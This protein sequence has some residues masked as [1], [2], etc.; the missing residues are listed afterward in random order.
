MSDFAKIVESYNGVS[1]FPTVGDPE[2]TY[3]DLIGGYEYR[4]VT[5][6]AAGVDAGEYV[7][8]NPQIREFRSQE[9]FE[10]IVRA[11]GVLYIVHG[12]GGDKLHYIWKDQAFW[13]TNEEEFFKLYPLPTPDP[14]FKQIDVAT[15]SSADRRK[16]PVLDSRGQ[17]D[18]GLIARDRLTLRQK[19]LRNFKRTI[20]SAF[21]SIVFLIG[22]GGYLGYQEWNNRVMEWRTDY[23]MCYIKLGNTVVEGQRKFRYQA[24][25][26][27]GFRYSS[28]SGVE[29]TTYLKTSGLAFRVVG[30]NAE[31]PWIKTN[32]VNGRD[33]Y[34]LEE[35]DRYTFITANDIEV[36]EY[37]EFCGN[38]RP[39]EE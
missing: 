34:E 31:G 39:V 5:N 19:T 23:H 6:Y 1:E 33:M 12:E 27:A 29:E 16:V 13:A 26:I 36:V 37:A 24:T 11:E 14:G 21:V 10:D 2:I 17:I 30:H 28:N 3:R 35:S 38:A 8:C 9:E 32:S 4:W 7:K 18:V 22:L 15:V 25:T 20:Y